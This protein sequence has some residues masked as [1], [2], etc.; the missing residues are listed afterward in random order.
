MKRWA[1]G[2]TIYKDRERWKSFGLIPWGSLIQH[3]PFSGCCECDIFVWIIVTILTDWLAVWLTLSSTEPHK[4]CCLVVFKISK[5]NTERAVSALQLYYTCRLHIY[6]MCIALCITPLPCCLCSAVYF[7]IVPEH[8]TALSYCLCTVMYFVFLQLHLRHHC[9]DL[10]VM[11]Y[12]Y[13]V[14]Y[15]HVMLNCISV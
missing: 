12:F 11:Y 6:N 2:S 13:F 9:I 8:I 4:A 10:L 7:V 5:I 14:L 15:C 1:V 3:N